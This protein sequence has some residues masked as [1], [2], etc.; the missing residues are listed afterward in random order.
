MGGGVDAPFWQFGGI[1][2]RRKSMVRAGS[3]FASFMR[4]SWL[5]LA[6]GLFC[7]EDVVSQF[8]GHFMFAL[9]LPSSKP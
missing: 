5:V 6:I 2:N 7:F 1:V 3:G 4:V 8:Q 9:L